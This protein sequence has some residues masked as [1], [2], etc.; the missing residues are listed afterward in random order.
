M[1]ERTAGLWFV[2]INIQL[3]I[4]FALLICVR[5]SSVGRRLDV[6]GLSGWALAAFSLFHANLMPAWDVW[7]VYFFPYFFMGVVV[8]RRV[9]DGQRL[10]FYAYQAL[11][12]LAM[13]FEWRWRLGVAMV[14][15][16]LLVWSLESGFAARWP[17]QAALLWLGRI[18]YSLFLVHFPV[19]VFVAALWSH[20]E[21]TSPLLA[22]MGLVVAFFASLALA[23]V[24]YRWIEAPSA[25]AA[26]QI[27]RSKRQSVLALADSR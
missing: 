1:F 20:L 25:R 26:R 21:W 17:R 24:F 7:A 23:A 5:D 15:G 12:L 22:S 10:E 18:S 11:F 27:G 8:W 13:L 6:I 3:C 9:N 14:V 16:A 2:C 19:L 4:L